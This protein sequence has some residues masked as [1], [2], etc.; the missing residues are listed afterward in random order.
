MIPDRGDTKL[1]DALLALR[2]E[3]ERAQKKAAERGRWKDCERSYAN[4]NY[5]GIPHAEW[6]SMND[7][8]MT[9]ESI[10]RT[11][12]LL[13]DA[14]PK[15]I[16]NGRGPED[17]LATHHMMLGID[18]AM[19][20]QDLLL[21]LPRVLRDA[22]KIGT[23]FLATRIEV[24]GLKVKF[25][26]D[27][28]SA[29]N[30]FPDAQATSDTDLQFVWIKRP[31]RLSRLLQIYPT[32]VNEIMD[33]VGSDVSKDPRIQL[34]TA[35]SEL[36]PSPTWGGTSNADGDTEVM[37]IT[38]GGT[39]NVHTQFVDLWE[40]Y[41]RDGDQLNVEVEL[42]DGSREIVPEEKYPGGRIVT[43]IG[44]LILDDIPNP[45]AHR[46]IPLTRV[47]CY[48][49]TGRYFGQSFIEA[50]LDPH[51]IISRI[52][53]KIM[54]WMELAA[55]PERV[56]DEDAGVDTEHDFS[57]PGKVVSIKPGARYDIL[58]PAEMP[59][60]IWNL[61]AA[62]VQEFNNAVGIS[63]V[64]RGNLGTLEDVSG[65]AIDAANEPNQQR[66]RLIQRNFEAAISRWGRQ[67][68]ANMVQ[69]RP[70]EEWLRVLPP[71]TVDLGWEHW[72]ED[73]LSEWPDVV[74]TV[75]SSLPVNKAAR[76]NEYLMLYREGLL[77]MPG[78]PEAASIVLDAIDLPDKDKALQNISAAFQQQQMMAQQQMMM[79]GQAQGPP[80]SSP[81]RSYLDKAAGGE[82][83]PEEVFNDE[84][85]LEAPDPGAE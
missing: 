36:S 33:R 83:D 21:L 78:T 8:P 68:V 67:S 77:G 38:R 25:V 44:D 70:R 42:A 34:H 1:V 65:K 46:Q 20:Q 79:Q 41:F 2:S 13:T 15:L 32:R 82:P 59:A 4:R 48:D 54:D 43:M 30:V 11:V 62:K 14:K 75:G 61:R 3:A 53:N 69:F 52:D 24:R 16:I 50:L 45:F 51:S 39:G 19:E 23:S 72:T 47:V 9:W 27:H 35:D 7:A 60:Y 80:S 37:E 22:L 17:A 84:V 29:W 63:E 28:V 81:S 64:S 31:I 66:V 58:K 56:V 18:Q 85:R 10:E 74:M 71:G 12:P 49:S 55:D 40:G 26:T 76:R 57:A 73:D 6:Q 5:H